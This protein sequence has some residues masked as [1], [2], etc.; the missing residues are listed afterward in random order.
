M[1]MYGCNTTPSQTRDRAGSILFIIFFGS[2]GSPGCADSS[3]RYRLVVGIDSGPAV[4]DHFALFSVGDQDLRTRLQDVFAFLRTGDTG[5]AVAFTLITGAQQ[6]A[7]PRSFNS[8][9]CLLQYCSG[10]EN[11]PD[12][13]GISPHK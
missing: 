8:V 13:V 1:N 11:P 7:R 4:P 12:N 9:G 2:L 3:H 10:V 5:G 6:R